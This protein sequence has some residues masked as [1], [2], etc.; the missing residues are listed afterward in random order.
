M[1]ERQQM[2]MRPVKRAMQG[3]WLILILGGASLLA[4]NLLA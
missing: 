2:R 4:R 3:M 1:A